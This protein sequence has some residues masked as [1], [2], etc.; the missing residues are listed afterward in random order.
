MQLIPPLIWNFLFF[1]L[2][3]NMHPAL[4]HAAPAIPRPSHPH[5][6]IILPHNVGGITPMSTLNDIKKLFGSKN[7]HA[8]AVPVA[9]GETSPGVRVY[10]GTDHELIIEW[11]KKGTPENI[12][13]SGR[14]TSKWKTPEGITLGTRLTEVERIN[15]KPFKLTGFRSFFSGLVTSWEG[16]K[17]PRSFGVSFSEPSN[18]TATQINQLIGED[19]ILTSDHSFLRKKEGEP[20]V[21]SLHIYWSDQKLTTEAPKASPSTKRK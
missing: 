3:Q 11:N 17:L 9:E 5:S 13:I 21:M 1:I 2:A 16:G 7:V 18:L 20:K 6:F 19:L 12:T 15:E 4:L 14:T 10:P 8:Y